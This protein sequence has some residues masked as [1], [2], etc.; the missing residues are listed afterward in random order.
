MAAAA[1]VA[2]SRPAE[3]SS[4]QVDVAQLLEEHH[5]VAWS[6]SERERLMFAMQLAACL[7]T[8]RDSEVWVLHGQQITNLESFCTQLERITGVASLARTIHGPGGVVDLLRQRRADAAGQASTKVR[9]YLWQDANV[10]LRRDH[11]LFGQLVDAITGVAAEAEYASEDLLLIHRGIFVGAP[12]LDVYAED[13]RG[14]FRCWAREGEERALWEVV[15]GLACPPVLRYRI[16]G[17]TSEPRVVITSSWLPTPSVLPP[18][19]GRP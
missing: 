5:L 15:S 14:Q 6:P 16:T 8:L 10:L 3:F 1:T 11:R 13:P 9:Y 19:S 4:W 18:H 7:R 12:S 2:A 17:V